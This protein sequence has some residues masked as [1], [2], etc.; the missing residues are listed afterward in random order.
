LSARASGQVWKLSRHK[1][2]ELLVLLAIAD[3]AKDDGRDAW[4]GIPELARKT[5]LTER[6]IQLVLRK[7]EKSGEL[8]IERNAGPNRANLYH[9]ILNGENI[10]PSNGEKIAPSDGE[11]ISPV[12]SF[13]GEIQRTQMVKSSVPTSQIPPK[14]PYKEELI[15]LTVKEPSVGTRAT[16]PRETLA[17]F[18]PTEK[19]I[20]DAIGYGVPEERI[21]FHTEQWRD[22]H[23]EKGTTIKD[24]GASWRRW[25]RNQVIYA[26]RDA[27]RGRASPATNGQRPVTY[28]EVRQENGAAAFAKVRAIYGGEGDGVPD[29]RDGDDAFVQR[30]EPRPGAG[31]DRRLLGAPRREQR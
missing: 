6:N 17:A 4:P 15:K 5:R 12:K 28:T 8:V 29:V 19:Q 31:A 24:L 16:K 22:Y 23:L 3:N 27:A 11:E 7:L 18:E 10:S 30:V 14:P 2:S 21:G 25:M 1:G 20:E 26:E 13:Q 9:I